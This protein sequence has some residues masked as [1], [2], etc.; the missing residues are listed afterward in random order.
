MSRS[1]NYPDDIR[2]YD[3]VP[4]SPFYEDPNEW[5]PIKATEQAEA[6]LEELGTTGKIKEEDWSLADLVVLMA[7]AGM[8]PDIPQERLHFLE[9]YILKLIESRPEDYTELDLNWR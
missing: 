9:A 3:N 2:Q 6:W 8:D 7:E 4:G 1:D 5:M